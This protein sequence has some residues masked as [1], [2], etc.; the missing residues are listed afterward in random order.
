MFIPLCVKKNLS[1][2]NWYHC[3]KRRIW[4]GHILK[5]MMKEFILLPYCHVPVVMLNET[6]CCDL[7]DVWARHGA[8]KGKYWC[9]TSHLSYLNPWT[10]PLFD[11]SSGQ[12]HHRRIVI[13]IIILSS[14][15]SKKRKIWQQSIIYT[16]A[17]SW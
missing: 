17:G 16:I 5:I 9:V 3:W 4:V 14:S 2:S 12:H 15:L 8:S 1:T 10:S 11:T 13:I 6:F 7:V